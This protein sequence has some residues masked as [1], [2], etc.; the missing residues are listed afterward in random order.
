MAAVGRRSFK[1]GNP[2]FSAELSAYYTREVGALMKS[3]I[4]DILHKNEGSQHFRRETAP[5][6]RLRQPTY[7]VLVGVK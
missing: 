4:P 6:L 7:F 5:L 2:S 1:S 3:L